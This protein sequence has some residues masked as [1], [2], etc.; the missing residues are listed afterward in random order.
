MKEAL[1]YVDFNKGQAT[2]LGGLGLRTDHLLYNL[3]LLGR[4]PGKVFL[5]SS[6]EWIFAASGLVSLMYKGQPISIYPLFQ[7]AQVSSSGLFWE[8]D[9]IDLHQS[10]V[11]QSNRATRDEV[12]LDISKGTVICI[13]QTS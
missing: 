8:L 13:L 1:S 3:C 4:Y 6:N 11:S 5:E 12:M 9:Q 7:K 2:I 10:F